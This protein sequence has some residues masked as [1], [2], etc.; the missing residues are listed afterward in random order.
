MTYQFIQPLVG[1]I[2]IGLASWLLLAALG[3]V[4]GVSSI[5]ADV[6]APDKADTMQSGWRLV[7]VLGL[8]VGGLLFSQFF[9]AVVTPQR[10]IWLLIVAGLLV[11][12]GTVVG[13][14]CTS[15][16]GVCGLGRRSV[17]SL[18]AVLV[19]MAAGMATVAIV[20]TLTGKSMI[21]I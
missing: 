8:I 9:S 19:F 7:F 2:F 12:V 20:L 11:G 14:G 21:S 1:G 4:A 18:A 16:H 13:S 6:V 17:R 15:G 3:R 5:M 10:P